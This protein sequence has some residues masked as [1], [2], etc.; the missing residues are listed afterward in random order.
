MEP[1]MIIEAGEKFIVRKG[2]YIFE[3]NFTYMRLFVFK[4]NTSSF[5]V[6]HVKHIFFIDL[7]LSH[8]DNKKNVLLSLIKGEINISFPCLLRL[9]VF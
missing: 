9:L 5:P 3:E 1:D 2:L 7:F 6:L 8:V 4:G